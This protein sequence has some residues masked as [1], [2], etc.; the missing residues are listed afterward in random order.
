[1]KESPRNFAVG[2][3]MILAFSALGMLMVMFGESPEWLGGAEY[4]LSIRFTDLDGVAEGTPVLLNGVQVGRV[5]PLE[6]NDPRRPDLGVTVIALIKEQ[7][8]IPKGATAEVQPPVLGIGRGRIEIMPPEKQS[9]PLGHKDATIYGFMGNPFRDIIPGTFITSLEDT[10]VQI[11]ALSEAAKPLAEDLHKLFM[12]RTIEEVDQPM[13]GVEEV[14]ANLY[15][16]VQRLDRLL[17]NVNDIVGDGTAKSS[18]LTTLENLEAMSANGREAFAALNKTSQELDSRLDR[19][20]ELL[21]GGITDASKAVDEIRAALLPALDTASQLLTNLNRAS[22]ALAE[23]E[24]TAALM[25]N[26]PRLYEVMV[27]SIERLTETL[28]TVRRLFDRFE[29]QGYIEF[30]AKSA[31]GPLD[32]RGRQDL[33][34]P[35][36]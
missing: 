24:G 12:V 21:E 6:F 10:V 13:P 27:L 36:E 4:R 16:A 7:Y 26:D 25:L 8:S 2:L 20:T 11:G 3:F 34:P 19:L 22:V 5:G 28:D 9:E 29:R 23:G 31:V 30:K 35:G 18:I 14:T 15:T 1:M 17:K 33:P 32:Y